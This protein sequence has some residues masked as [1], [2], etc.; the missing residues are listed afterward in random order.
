MVILVKWQIVEGNKKLHKKDAKASTLKQCI[1]FPWANIFWSASKFSIQLCFRCKYFLFHISKHLSTNSVSFNKF[2]YNTFSY[3]HRD[4]NKVGRTDE[5][6]TSLYNWLDIPESWIY[7]I[8]LK[9][10]F[11]IV[12]WGFIKLFMS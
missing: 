12:C 3:D 7:N 11:K 4:K 8:R 9:H 5:P 6:H 10:F 1:V 2:S